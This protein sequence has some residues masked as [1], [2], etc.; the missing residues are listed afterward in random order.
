MTPASHCCDPHLHATI[1]MPGRYL[2]MGGNKSAPC[3]GRGFGS[4][5]N[6]FSR[7]KRGGASIGGRCPRLSPPILVICRGRDLD[8]GER[9]AYESFPFCPGELSHMSLQGHTWST[10]R[11]C[12]SPRCGKLIMSGRGSSSRAHA[13]TLPHHV[14]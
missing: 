14:P 1:K 12:F 9:S 6:E 3:Q 4:H 5:Q 8:R 11:I 7:K 13:L 10:G 2:S